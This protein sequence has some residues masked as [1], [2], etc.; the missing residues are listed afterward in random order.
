MLNRII[1]K[2]NNK[3]G[4]TLVEVI[5]VIVILAILAAIAIP[6]LTGYIDKANEKKYISVV[7]TNMTAMQTLLSEEYGGHGS[8]DGWGTFGESPSGKIHNGFVTGLNSDGTLT[9]QLRDTDS[10]YT[11]AQEDALGDEWESLTGTNPFEP[12]ASGG[13][14]V[15]FQAVIDPTTYQIKGFGM[16]ILKGGTPEYFVTWN[17][18]ETRA[19]IF[20][21]GNL[22][23]F[24]C[25][26]ADESGYQVFTVDEIMSLS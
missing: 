3:K 6:A 10:G 20:H 11:Q 5:V 14:H 23:E 25:T 4:F 7:R 24:F 8:Y 26:E 19:T 21:N 13:S 2:I 15:S 17:L 12:W 9:V 16:V 22:G 1:K 18:K